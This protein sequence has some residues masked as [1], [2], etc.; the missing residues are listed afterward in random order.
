MKLEQTHD[1]LVESTQKN[2]WSAQDA[3][4]PNTREWRILAHDKEVQW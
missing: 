2:V 1:Y 3:I 4:R